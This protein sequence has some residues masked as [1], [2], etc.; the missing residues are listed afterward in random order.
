MAQ[1]L[2]TGGSLT[3]GS[4]LELALQLVE[5]RL[6][7]WASNSDAY[8]ALLQRVFGADKASPPGKLPPICKPACW[9]T[10]SKFP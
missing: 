2:F 4:N 10:A 5:N 7:A 3:N 8:N 6:A 9:R 1:L